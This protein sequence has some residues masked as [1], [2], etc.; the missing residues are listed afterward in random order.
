MPA[1]VRY[2]FTV[3]RRHPF[4]SRYLFQMA[5]RKSL[6]ESTLTSILDGGYLTENPERAKRKDEQK[7]DIDAPPLS[8]STEV[9]RNQTQKILQKPNENKR[10][11]ASRRWSSEYYPNS[12]SKGLLAILYGNNREEE[13]SDE[14]DNQYLDQ[15]VDNRSDHA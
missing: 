1:S 10:T 8:P 14:E 12:T 4:P 7:I 3:N 5:Y 6:Q 15:D 11:T 9:G 2:A 13:S